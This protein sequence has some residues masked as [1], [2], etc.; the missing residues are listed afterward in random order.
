LKLIIKVC[1]FF[2]YKKILTYYI[3][4]IIFCLGICPLDEDFLVLLNNA[5]F[6]F[7]ICQNKTDDDDDD[8]TLSALYILCSNLMY[9]YI[10]CAMFHEKC[11]DCYIHTASY[12]HFKLIFKLHSYSN[13][14]CCYVILNDINTSLQ[15]FFE[16]FKTDKYIYLNENRKIFRCHYLYLRFLKSYFKTKYGY[17]N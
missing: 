11:L 6:P 13:K 12:D 14:I 1:V 8:D 16:R 4:F 2:Y 9:E 10:F 15:F 7:L 17:N 3:I 5:K